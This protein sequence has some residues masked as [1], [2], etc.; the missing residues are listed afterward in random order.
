MKRV[1]Y[2]IPY[3]A[4]VIG[5]KKKT[6]PRL[7]QKHQKIKRV[8]TKLATKHDSKNHKIS[9]SKAQSIKKT[10]Y[11]QCLFENGDQQ[12]KQIIN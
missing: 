3:C 9:G 2:L 1:K 8:A 7:R 4:Q 5:I 11:I 10:D 6:L 12:P